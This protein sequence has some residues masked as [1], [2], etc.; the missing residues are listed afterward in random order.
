MI[1][2]LSVWG[3]PSSTFMRKTVRESIVEIANVIFSPDSGGMRNTHLKGEIC[4]V[5]N[6]SDNKNKFSV[7]SISYMFQVFCAYFGDLT[8]KA[9]MLMRRAG[10]K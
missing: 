4:M 5:G 9:R 1:G 8:H 7:I 10:A 6:H 3:M 2:I